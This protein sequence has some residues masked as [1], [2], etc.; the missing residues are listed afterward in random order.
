MSNRYQT[1]L[2]DLDATLIDNAAA[3]RSLFPTLRQMYPILSGKEERLL[4]IGEKSYVALCEELK[5]TSAPTYKAFW[6]GIWHLYV[7]ATVCFPWTVSTLKALR[8][9]GYRLGMITNGDAYGQNAKIDS[10]NLRQYFDVILVSGTVGISKP[11]PA[12]YALALEQLGTE[13]QSALFVGD[14]PKTDI[15]GAQNAGIDSFLL[16]KG[17][18][19]FG[20]TYTGADISCLLKLL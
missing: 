19:T 3:F 13:K 20:A 12:I 9:K 16:T 14:N 6:E 11:D 4:P 5:W 2:F 1:I 18:E 15:L 10:G 7:H 8:E 17:E